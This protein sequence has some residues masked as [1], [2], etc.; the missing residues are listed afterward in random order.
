MVAGRPLE[1][2]EN[3]FLKDEKN[4]RFYNSL[5]SSNTQLYLMKSYFLVFNFPHEGEFQFILLFLFKEV[6]MKMF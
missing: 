2:K 6:R 1:G 3:W 5:W 4:L